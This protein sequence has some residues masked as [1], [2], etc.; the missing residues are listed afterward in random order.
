M[1]FSDLIS[2][3]MPEVPGCNVIAIERALLNGAREF[4]ARTWAW[5]HSPTITIRA[6]KVFAAIGYKIPS[7]TSVLGI[8]KWESDDTSVAPA[9]RNGNSELFVDDAPTVD[10]AYTVTLALQPGRT[11][12]EYPD[13]MDNAYRDAVTAHAKHELMMMPE[14]TWSNPARAQVLYTIF[15]DA[16]NDAKRAKNTSRLRGRMMM[17]VP[18]VR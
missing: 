9:L 13:W 1:K 15:T 7:K 16:V 8:V 11:A 2:Y 6:G 10:T 3:V 4:C 18:G 5:E 14:K 17:R 12:D